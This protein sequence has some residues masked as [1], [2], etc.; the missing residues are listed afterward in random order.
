MRHSHFFLIAAALLLAGSGCAPSVVRPEPGSERVR[1]T[2]TFYPLAFLAE[3]VGGEFVD[4]AN[5]TPA[6]S[7]PHDFEPTGQDVALIYESDVFLYNGG[8]IDAWATDIA[9]DVAGAGA[10]VI[11]MTRVVGE[12]LPPA[13]PGDAFDEHVWLDPNLLALEVP[14]V[15]DAF[16]ASDARHAAAYEAN[17]AALVADLNELDAEYRAALASC[18]TPVAVTAHA[19]LGYLA[20]R[21]GFEQLPI[22][23][24][25]PDDEPSAGD[26]AELARQA[27][28]RNVAYIFFE[29]LVNPELAQT[30]AREIGAQTLV[31]NPLE[32]LTDQEIASGADYFTVMRENLT[33]LETAM[34]CR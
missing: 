18:E 25:S 2:T 17:A 16:V 10:R 13:E 12:L 21:Y 24:I 8:G 19:V 1:V 5:L 14:V 3:R 22:A 32:G 7:E 4:V 30:L 27:E 31:L 6:G 23:G 26:L 20:K 9:P 11:E 29:T 33:N 15:R 28:E 34:L